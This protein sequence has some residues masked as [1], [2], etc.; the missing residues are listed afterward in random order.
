MLNDGGKQATHAK[1]SKSVTEYRS[2][3]I[4]NLFSS[5]WCFDLTVDEMC[6]HSLLG[7]EE[8]RVRSLLGVHPHS[9]VPCCVEGVDDRCTLVELLCV[10]LRSNQGVHVWPTSLGTP[11]IT[12]PRSVTPT[13]LLE[14]YLECFI[15]EVLGGSWLRRGG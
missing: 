9:S 7:D 13:K 4:Y 11:I 5:F 1:R 12:M 2:T 15:F 14:T 6:C 3:H 8:L 10:F